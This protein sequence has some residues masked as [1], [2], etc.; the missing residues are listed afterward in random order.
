MFN[1]IFNEKLAEISGHFGPVHCV[2]FSPDGH[3]FA[4]AAEEGYVH[5]HR[6]PPEYFTKKFEWL[7][8]YFY[9]KLLFYHF[10]LDDYFVS[11]P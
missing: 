4:S 7:N 10:L 1:L 3:A 11:L 6:F 2:S 8:I 9:F 5:Y